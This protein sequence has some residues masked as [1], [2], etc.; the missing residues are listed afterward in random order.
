MRF[1]PISAPNK[2]RFPV[3]AVYTEEVSPRETGFSGFETS[4]STNY[5]DLTIKNSS[6]IIRYNVWNWKGWD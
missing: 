5:V 1:S 3:E 4:G 6:W 2:L